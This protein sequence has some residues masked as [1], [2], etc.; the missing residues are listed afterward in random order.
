[1]LTIPTNMQTALKKNPNQE[2]RYI[3][4]IGR[5]LIAS[6]YTASN[7]YISSNA[8]FGTNNVGITDSIVYPV[9][10]ILL[11]EP[12]ITEQLDIRAHTSTVGGFSIELDDNFLFQNPAHSNAL[13]KFSDQ[14][15]T[16][17]I[18]NRDLYIYLW[19]SGLT[20][21]QTECLKVY[22]GIVGDVKIS[23]NKVII[24]ISNSTF[25]V[26]KELPQKIINVNDHPLAPSESIG[27][28]YSLVYGQHKYLYCN[29]N[30]S[31]ATSVELNNLIPC[32][33][34]GLNT[35]NKHR[36]VISSNKCKS[37]DELWIYD[38]QLAK[39][40]KIYSQ[41]TIESNNEVDGAIVIIDNNL[42]YTDYHLSDGNVTATR[43]GSFVTTFSNP[44]RAGDKAFDLAT[45]GSINAGAGLGTWI[46]IAIQF[47]DWNN[48]TIDDANII[49]IDV[50]LFAKYEATGLGGQPYYFWFKIECSFDDINWEDITYQFPTNET[51]VENIRLT[52]ISHNKANI[53][54]TL[55]L[56]ITKIKTD[57]GAA[58]T[59][60]ITIYEAFKSIR[61][62]ST[63]FS[64]VFASVN[65]RE[66]SVPVANVLYSLSAG[67]LVEHPAAIITSLLI[68]E[69][70]DTNIDVSSVNNV[71]TELAGWKGS[72]N[73]DSFM[74]SKELIEKIAKQSKLFVYWNAFNK[75]AMDTFYASNTTDYIFSINDIQGRPSLSKSS[76]D[77]IVNNFKFKYHKSPKGNLQLVIT[78]A[79]DTANTGSQAV[80]NTVNEL[81]MEADFISDNNTAGL[82]ADHW[83]KNGDDPSFWS[84]L[85][86][87]IEFETVDLRGVN[88]WNAGNFKPIM[89]L[90]LTDIIELNSDWD[91][92]MKC[93]GESWSGK[94]F[95]IISITR[96]PDSL[97]I[98][99]ISL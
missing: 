71:I 43:Y 28:P 78:R 54:A 12:D 72:V 5:S 75:P 76:L 89:G 61:Y 25:K 86:N 33:Y 21:L 73:V 10:P 24:P 53:G 85:H 81:V 91:N 96:K 65:G 16:Y 93:F 46:K 95:K 30:K 68:D 70:G 11:K 79:N 35:N 40:T 94:Q 19:L 80:Y 87:I 32:H 69:L 67:D 99:A 17:N 47:P 62:R 2:F 51:T 7:F 37:I 88:C 42:V 34:I 84:I 14:L 60:T 36:W 20:N 92:I 3:I 49:R 59:T 39:Y 13:E 8:T 83:C 38:T 50:S 27:L 90:E 55:Y 41:W 64:Q 52:T 66:A 6:P 56:K 22:H 98:K 44:T 74:G 23:N 9:V 4:K 48:Q 57:A 18:Y 29:P 82:L 1:M 26:Q 77:D 31:L 63:N 97:K 15:N 58:P 45:V